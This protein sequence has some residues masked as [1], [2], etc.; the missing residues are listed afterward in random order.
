MKLDGLRRLRTSWQL[1][2]A[3]CVVGLI[4]AG[5]AAAVSSRSAV[6]PGNSSLPSISGTTTVGSTVTANPGTWTGSAPI[7][8]QYQWRVCD[9]N[10]AA[11]RDISG[12]TTSTYQ[13]RS[14][15]AGN[16]LR[17]EVIASNPDGS[18]SATSGPSTKVAAVSNAPVN[19]TPPTFSGGTNAGG[20]LTASPGTWSGASPISFQYQ[21]LICDGT[22]AAC[23]EIAGATAQS[24]QLRDGDVGNTVRVRVIAANADGSS[25]STSGPSDAI[26]KT[27]QTASTGC[28]KTTA[29]TQVVSV[30]DLSPPAR[31]L[32][33]QFVPSPSVI[34]RSLG[35]FM[36]RFHV[37]STCGQAVQ[38]AQI[39]AT[40]VP[41]GQVTIPAQQQTDANG[42]VTLQFNRL[43][44]FPAARGQQLMVLFVRATKPGD[45]I[46]AGISTRRLISLRVN[47]NG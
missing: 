35:S 28:A 15:D 30:A 12:A 42:D 6:A 33:T 17:V 38:G 46:L 23:H 20:T 43:S 16:T 27:S 19:S 11:C 14:G 29:A 36:V 10:G 9:A 37:A 2:V 40:A 24:Y 41:Y 25:S 5:T 34:T 44:G 31:L 1:V 26:T 21:W 3:G 47:L 32:I 39:Y 8:F 45:P 18:S 7:G 13:L 4:V 22:G